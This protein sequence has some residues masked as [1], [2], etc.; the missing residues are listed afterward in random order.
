MS[1]NNAKKNE[2]SPQPSDQ[3]AKKIMEET[4]KEKKEKAEEEMEQPEKV[5]LSLYND[6]DLK[7]VPEAKKGEKAPKGL[8]KKAAKK[9]SKKPKK[10]SEEKQ[11]A[12]GEFLMKFQEKYNKISD[13]E[14]RKALDEGAERA[15]P[16][17]EETLNKVKEL[18]GVN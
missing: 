9:K 1:E 10:E 6:K 18:I 17:A 5:E 3:E 11:T 12:V 15:R 2:P 16:I 7:A 14:V 13:E 8:K 4:E